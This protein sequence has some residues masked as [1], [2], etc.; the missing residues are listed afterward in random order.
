MSDKE[1]SLPIVVTIGFAGSRRLFDAEGLSADQKA[2]ATKEIERRLGDEIDRLRDALS[3]QPHHFLCGLSQIA[4]GA[5]TLFARVCAERRIAGRIVLPQPLDHYLAAVNS[6][7]VPDFNADQIQEAERL[8]RDEHMIDLRVVTH[9]RDRKTRFT[10]VNL[11]ILRE[12]DAVVCLVRADAEIDPSGARGLLEMAKRAKKPALELEIVVEGGRPQV[13]PRWH[14]LEDGP[15]SPPALPPVLVGSA[16]LALP[17]DLPPGLPVDAET[18]IAR[19]KALGSEAAKDRR[20]EFERAGRT[21]LGT[22]FLATTCAVSALVLPKGPWIAAL[23]A[24][25][26]GLLATGL[27]RHRS[28]HR[29]HAT[30]GWATAR[31]IAQIGRS[32]WALRGLPVRLDH[33]FELAVPDDLHPLLRTIDALHLAESRR[34]PGDWKAKRD[35]YR[36][37]RIQ[38]Q[39]RY[40]ADKKEEAEAQ[41]RNANLAFYAGSVGALLAT[42]IKFGLELRHG[43]GPTLAALGSLAVLLPVVAV[44]ALSRTAS[45]DTEARIH[46]NGDMLKYLED[47]DAKVKAA[48]SSSEFLHHVMAIERHLLGETVL[49]AS[50]RSFTGVS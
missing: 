46:T 5:D 43:H 31:L 38:G 30:R 22:H 26:W 35:H 45:L 42:S 3:L 33:L 20:K 49:W 2:E 41:Q 28:L 14:N 19:V 34:S 39:K 36:H 13:V 17:P 1:S 10:E 48:D 21:I 37:S 29:S 18:Y 11:A 40:F 12:S 27:A 7:G 32:A 8:E 9:A 25:E 44:A 15:W 4:I 24:V 23:L 6:K 50:R 16:V 47:A